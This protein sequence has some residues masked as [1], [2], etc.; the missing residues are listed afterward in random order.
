MFPGKYGVAKPWNFLYK[1]IRRLY[2]SKREKP[3]IKHELQNFDEDKLYF[4]SEPTNVRVGIE[5]HNMT[6]KFTK[7]KI[8]VNDLTLNIYENQITCLLGQVN[9][10]IFK[11]QSNYCE[12]QKSNE[13]IPLRA[14]WSG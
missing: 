3:Q 5:I 6:K 14:E 2:F 10:L 13:L 12:I 11:F 8:S 7:D 1:K 4:E 9:V